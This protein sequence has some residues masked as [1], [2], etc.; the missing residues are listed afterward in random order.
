MIIIE[1]YMDDG[2]GKL[3]DYKF[4][5]FNGMSY[6]LWVD[7]DRF[8]NHRRNVYDLNWNLLNC[9]NLGYSNFPSPPKPQKLSDM[10]TIASI[11]SR[12]FSYV[13]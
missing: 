1:Q 8:E 13:R 10:I 3:L 11:L 7:S 4:T 9:R 6:F 5:C 2:S 12:D